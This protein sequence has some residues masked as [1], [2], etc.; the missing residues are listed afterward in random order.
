MDSFFSNAL[1]QANEY[2][3]YFS[4]RVRIVIMSHQ[5]SQGDLLCRPQGNSEAYQQVYHNAVQVKQVLIDM[6]AAEVK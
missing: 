2:R 5:S 3:A 4:D 1:G 6:D